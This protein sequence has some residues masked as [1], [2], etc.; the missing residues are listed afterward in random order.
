MRKKAWFT[1]LGI[2]LYVFFTQYSLAAPPFGSV[3]SPADNVTVIGVIPVSGWVLDD[4]EV[5]RVQVYR[6]DGWDLV[7]LG[8]GNFVEG[9]RPDIAAAYPEY[10]NNDRAGWG[11][12]LV[13]NFLPNG[14]NG[15]YKLYITATDSDGFE[16]ILG[17]R[18][19]RCDNAN[20]VKPFG[21]FDTPQIGETISGQYYNWGWVLT[22]LPN[23]IPP[24]GSTIRVYIDGAYVGNATYNIYRADIA[25]LLP[26]Y[27]NSSGPV[28]YYVI[29]TTA[30]ANGLHTLQW[31]VTDTAGNTDGIGSRYFRIGSGGGGPTTS[32]PTVTTA[33][34]SNITSTSASS[35]GNVTDDGGASVTAR[36]VCWSTSAN[37]TTGDS[38]TSNGSG[39]GSFTSSITGLTAGQTY[40]VRAYATNS[41]DTSYG[42]DVSFTT[43]GGGTTPA[44]SINITNPTNGASVSGAII[45]SAELSSSRTANTS[46]TGKSTPDV[47]FYIDNTLVKTDTQPPFKYRWVT[48]RE[49]N[50]SHTI[51]AK[52]VYTS[53]QS[54]EDQIS[55]TVNNSTEA[56]QISLNRTRLNFAVITG[57]PAPGSQSFLIANSGGGALSWTASVSGSWLQVTPS[58]GSDGTQVNVSVDASGL[59]VGNNTGTISISDPNAG[60]SPQTVT[61]YL[62]VKRTG[63]DLPMVGSIDTPIDGTT[64]SG[65]V[66]V[67][68]WALDDTEVSAVGLYRNAV[69]EG[70]SGYIY[71]DD[72]VFVEGARPDVET[73]YSQYPRNYLA[74]WGYMMLTHFL[75]NNGNGTFVITAIAEDS[76]GN[77]AVLGSKTIH[78]DN[79][80]AVKPFGAIDTPAQGAEISGSTYINW[81]WALTP[82]PNTIPTDGSTIKV[83][84]D[85]VPLTGNPVYNKYR[86][87]IATYFPDYTNSVGAVGYYSLDTT[88]Y[89]NGVHMISWS[90][91]DD[92]GNSDGVGSRYFK[93]LND[94]STRN[95]TRTASSHRTPAQNAEISKHPVSLK[96]GYNNRT[97][98]QQLHPDAGGI[99]HIQMKSSERIEIDLN[100]PIKENIGNSFRG[101]LLKGKEQNPLPVGSF[102]DRGKGIFYW[103]PGPAFK[104]QFLLEFYR[105]DSNRN[106]T[107]KILKV[108]IRF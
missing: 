102:L 24:G 2:L 29:D 75:P 86:S 73:A 60:N 87:D 107:R 10:P 32:A 11:F 67:T 58:S 57:E 43:S 83:W 15:T 13:T 36:G 106:I 61:V 34:V 46:K 76:S 85:G 108:D 48:T 28:G 20:A 77:R 68:G 91:R 50:G 31:V 100:G 93:I 70:E 54:F 40:H 97:A 35:G 64:V 17:S 72:A 53:G 42:S 51:K 89:A 23:M 71:I 47:E 81:G 26:G 1:V 8:D 45:V 94:E 9:A 19:I 44:A 92:A 37:P 101:Y 4:V 12:S 90:V 103:Q 95:S 25:A 33:S 105:Q 5:T 49:T 7:Y 14:G 63:G 41:V 96:R 27:A 6:E 62:S 82:Q 21:T 65:S 98:P 30:Y 104:G 22:P 38:K 39:T 56:P 52:A 59:S 66:P 80:N 55:V 16:T 69:L 84:V 99:I 88:L 74:G 78:C 3:E 18:T 79:A